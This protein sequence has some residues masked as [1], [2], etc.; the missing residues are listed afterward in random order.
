MPIH[1]AG[2]Y[3]QKSHCWLKLCSKPRNAATPGSWAS[4]AVP[5][6]GDLLGT[7]TLSGPTEAEAGA[8]LE[9]T[10]GDKKPLTL[11]NG[12]TSTVLLD[13]NAVAFTGWCE[14]PGA[15]CIGFGECR[16][17]VLPARQARSA[18]RNPPAGSRPVFLCRI[19]RFDAGLRQVTS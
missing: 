8:L 10:E 5:P 17:T 2:I 13:G 18:H 14:K 12:G 1:P 15:A 3:I 7:G 19:C 9:I 16:A 11:P 6:S 4:L